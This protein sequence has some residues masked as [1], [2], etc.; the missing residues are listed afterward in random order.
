MSRRHSPCPHNL[1]ISG[2]AP[3][4]LIAPTDIGFGASASSQQGHWGRPAGLSLFGHKARR[5]SQAIDVALPRFARVLPRVHDNRPL[6]MGLASGS[7]HALLMF[8]CHQPPKRDGSS[9]RKYFATAA[10]IQGANRSPSATQEP[11]VR[12]RGRGGRGSARA[13]PATLSLCAKRILLTLK[14]FMLP[15]RGYRLRRWRRRA[16]ERVA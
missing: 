3:R 14:F 5:L 8:L 1:T 12:E 16:Q 13:T 11:C 4:P 15:L 10:S 2:P 7:P 6:S 9:T